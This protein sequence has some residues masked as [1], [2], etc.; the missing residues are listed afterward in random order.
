[1]ENDL[2][3]ILDSLNNLKALAEKKYKQFSS[4]LTEAEKKEAEAAIGEMNATDGLIEDAFKNLK[5]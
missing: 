1:M 2:R 3:N 5:V 4:T